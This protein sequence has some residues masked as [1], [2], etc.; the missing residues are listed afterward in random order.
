MGF[1][2]SFERFNARELSFAGFMHHS[3]DPGDKKWMYD[4]ENKAGYNSSDFFN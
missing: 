4:Q 3:Q 2:K 1:T